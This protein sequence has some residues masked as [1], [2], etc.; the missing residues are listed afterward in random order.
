MEFVGAVFNLASI[1]V[2]LSN[3][4]IKW[5]FHKVKGTASEQEIWGLG[6]ICKRIIILVSISP[7][8]VAFSWVYSKRKQEFSAFQYIP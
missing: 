2:R 7:L 8:P 3:A 6:A 1:L 5:C 4:A